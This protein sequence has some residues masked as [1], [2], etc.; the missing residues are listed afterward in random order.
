[1]RRIW[2]AIWTACPALFGAPNAGLADSCAATPNQ[3]RAAASASTLVTAQIRRQIT[4]IRAIERQRKC[5]AEK[6]TSG[7]IFNTCRDLARQRAEAE[8][9]LAKARGGGNLRCQAHSGARRKSTASQESGPR[10]GG[11][12]YRASSL[13]FCVRPSDGYFFPAP[14]SQF[15]KSDY[16]PVAVDQ[17]RF[18]C[19]DLTMSLYVLE[20][21][22]L[23]TEEMIS[24]VTKTS[25]RESFSTFRRQDHE[26]KTCNWRGYFARVNEL[27][28]RTVTPDNLENVGI[29]IPTF[30][31]DQ[32]DIFQSSAIDPA[33]ILDGL[34]RRVRVVGPAFLPDKNID[35]RK[36]RVRQ[37]NRIALPLVPQ[38]VSS[39]G[40]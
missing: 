36:I 17:C 27:R 34:Q 9:K 11:A 2:I 32:R 6:S 21:P 10:S 23:E 40:P 33:K 30:R 38:A 18:I 4:A 22:R 20:D 12:A 29:P 8:G 31:P 25:Y 15:A 16:S 37:P 19:Q 26:F 5:T 3:A 7:G 14:N 1:M 24:V 28:A 39:A 13:Y 35:F